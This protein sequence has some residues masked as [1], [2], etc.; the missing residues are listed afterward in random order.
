MQTCRERDFLYLP[1]PCP[2][3]FSYGKN[4]DR[5]LND[6][7]NRAC[8]RAFDIIASALGLIMISPLFAALYIAIRRSDGHDPIYSQERIG[9]H[10]RAFN[11]YKFRSMRPDAESQGEPQL[12]EGQE[13]N[14]LTPIGRFMRA[15]HL[16][17][18]PQLWNVLI[19]DMSFV[20]YRPERKYFINQIRALAPEYDQLYS[21]R[22][23]LFSYATLYNGYTDTMA[24]MLTRLRMDL[25]Y[26]HTASMWVD[27]KIIF[28]TIT[29]IIS[30][31]VF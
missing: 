13:D 21:M 31:K 3:D 2:F 16:D 6:R 24:K 23:G 28:L 15:H 22:P 18:I 20:G 27:A 11:I 14:R 5:P 1:I 9:L 8:K 29:S 25:E 12:C 17:E 10:G 19:G 4:S 26:M 7:V 30:G